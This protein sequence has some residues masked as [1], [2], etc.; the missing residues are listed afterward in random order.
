MA[1]RLNLFSKRYKDRSPQPL[2]GGALT[3]S[4]PV[5]T[6]PR[7]LHLGGLHGPLTRG[8]ALPVLR[9]A[10]RPLLQP[11]HRRTSSPR[12]ANRPHRCSATSILPVPLSCTPPTCP[13]WIPRLLR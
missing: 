12:Q 5:W 13:I 9:R 4:A 1:A 8:A 11:S 7:T 6:D 2:A 3:R 10:T